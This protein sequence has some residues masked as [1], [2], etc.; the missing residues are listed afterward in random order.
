MKLFIKGTETQARNALKARNINDYEVLRVNTS[1][2]V[3]RANIPHE[4]ATLWFTE[5]YDGPPFRA[6]SLLFYCY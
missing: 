2:V 4:A 1:E 3:V 6:G 5:D